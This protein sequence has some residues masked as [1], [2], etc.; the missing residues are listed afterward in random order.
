M[1]KHIKEIYGRDS[2]FVMPGIEIDRFRL[3]IDGSKIR[4]RFADK[5]DFFILTSNILHIRKRIDILIEAIPFVLKKYKNIKVIITGDGPEKTM[6]ENLIKELNLQKNVFLTSFVPIEDLPKYYAAC[7]VFAFT[8][9]REPQGGSYA[10]ALA[11]GK[12][13]IVP[14]E[15]APVESIIEGKTGFVFKSLDSQDLAK[16]IIWCIENK[17]YLKKMSKDCRKWIE[18]N[19]TWEKMT[20][21]TLEVFNRSVNKKGKRWEKFKNI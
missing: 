9:V 13:V 8:A 10:E 12:P 11:S 7:D 15:G 2:T 18:E 16:K 6:L 3:N 5:K 4:N 17:H 21:E 1:Q 19:R 20:K 14:D